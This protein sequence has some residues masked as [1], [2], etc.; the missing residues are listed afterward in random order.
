MKYA[1]NDKQELLLCPFDD[2][3]EGYTEITKEEYEELSKPSLDAIKGNKHSELKN[4]MTTKRQ[5]LTVSYDDDTFD[6]NENAQSNMMV[7]LKSFDLGAASVSI[8]SATEKTHTFNKEHT[9]ELSLLML[10]AVNNLYDTYWKLKDQL[11]KCETVD[12]VN[13]IKWE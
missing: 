13:E 1:V 6:A 11:S 4:V 12:E 9:Q 3:L 2:I 5:A 8:R 7:L 10:Q